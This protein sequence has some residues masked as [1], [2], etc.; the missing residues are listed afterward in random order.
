M[1]KHY[2]NVGT[3]THLNDCRSSGRLDNYSAMVIL[4]YFP[5]LAMAIKNES[6]I[7]GFRRDVAEG[8]I[9][10]NDVLKGYNDVT[11]LYK[12]HNI[13]IVWCESVPNYFENGD[14]ALKKESKQ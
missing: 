9:S 7:S 10:F 11:E 8:S 13:E 1:T 6:G 14:E 3:C 12:S 2:L 4:E 5:E